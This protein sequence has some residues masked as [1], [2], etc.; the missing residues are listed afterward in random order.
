MAAACFAS[1]L[2]SVVAMP[3]I[4]ACLAMVATERAL[5][6]RLVPGRYRKGPIPQREFATHHVAGRSTGLNDYKDIADIL[7]KLADTIGP[8]LER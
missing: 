5:Q 6:R 4:C 8:D 7:R 3:V 2:M 1:S